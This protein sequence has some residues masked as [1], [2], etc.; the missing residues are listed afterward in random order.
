L[1]IK[2]IIGLDQRKAPH[3]VVAIDEREGGLAALIG[4]AT[5]VQRTEATGRL[6][7]PLLQRG[8]HRRV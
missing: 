1:P 6:T 3:T 4:S 7:C 2:V 8:V 5:P